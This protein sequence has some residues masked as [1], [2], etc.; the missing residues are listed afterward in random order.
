MGS[1]YLPSFIHEVVGNEARTT[2]HLE[3]YLQL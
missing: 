3:L 2:D 1:A